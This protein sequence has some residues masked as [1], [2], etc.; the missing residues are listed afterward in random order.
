M[1][2]RSCHERRDAEGS[3]NISPLRGLSQSAKLNALIT[4]YSLLNQEPPAVASWPR[5][6][7]FVTGI[8]TKCLVPLAAARGSI[9]KAS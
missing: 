9:S 6:A 4:H 5:E 3:I 8:E 1:H 7:I 2:F